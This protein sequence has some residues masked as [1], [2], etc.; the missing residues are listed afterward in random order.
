[1]SL[2]LEEGFIVLDQLAQFGPEV[3]RHL[4]NPVLLLGKA[5]S[6]RVDPGR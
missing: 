5:A 2:E 4:E 1:V 6:T 3:D